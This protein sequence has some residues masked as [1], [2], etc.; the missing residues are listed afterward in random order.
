MQEEPR[1]AQLPEPFLSIVIPAYNEETRLPRALGSIAVYA[2]S[3]GFHLEVLV[4]DDGSR[5]GTAAAVT[6]MAEIWP[7]ARLLRNPGN[8]G[9]GYSVRH[10]MLEAAGQL[11]LFTDA[12]L[13][14]PI[15]EADRLLEALEAGHEVAIGSRALRPELIAV[16]Q[17]RMRETAGRIFNLLVRIF[18]RLP[19]RDT[20][21]GFKLFRREAARAVFGHQQIDGFGFDVEAL[22]LARKFGYRV[23]EVPVRW[24]HDPDTKVRMFQASVRMF[25]DLW[26]IHWMDFQGRYNRPREDAVPGPAQRSGREEP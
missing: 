7:A 16:H 3:K 5:D 19:F 18:T 26:R 25:A 21:C 24:S 9:K 15:E 23:A 12:D 22:Y 1:L 8:R 2:A 6:R 4:V 14:A 17:S 13:A 11:V 20:Q 10:G